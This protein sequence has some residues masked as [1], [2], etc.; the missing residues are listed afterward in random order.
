MNPST[1][2]LLDEYV[3]LTIKWMANG[4]KLTLVFNDSNNRVTTL[5]LTK[6]TNQ[7][8][9]INMKIIVKIVKVV[10]WVTA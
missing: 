6:P 4:C 8:Y 3:S 10:Q 5:L 7:K 1:K 9:E 2:I